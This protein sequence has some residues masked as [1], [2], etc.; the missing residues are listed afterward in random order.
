MLHEKPHTRD[1]SLASLLLHQCPES[2]PLSLWVSGPS[3]GARGAAGWPT[4]SAGSAAP[5]RRGVGMRSQ[6]GPWCQAGTPRHPLH[7]GGGRRK[8]AGPAGRCAPPERLD[9]AGEPGQLAF[10]YPLFGV[11][12]QYLKVCSGVGASYWLIQVCHFSPLGFIKVCHQVGGTWR[13]FYRD[14]ERR[15]G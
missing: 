12:V 3:P 13:S 6:A 5:L 11:S 8:D 10:F 4:G 14:N 1:V 7:G 9:D 2:L 15:R